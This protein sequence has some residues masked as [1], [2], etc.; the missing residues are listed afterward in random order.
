MNEFEL[1]NKYFLPLSSSDVKGDDCGIWEKVS[2]STDTSIEG[3]H[4]F[5]SMP[6]CDIA[7][8]T[9]RIAASDLYACG[10]RGVGYTLALSF[11]KTYEEKWIA[12][13]A[14]GLKKTQKALSLKLFGGDTTC[15]PGKTSIT[16]TVFGVISKQPLLR[17][18]A[19]AG[20][21]VFVSGVLGEAAAYCYLIK[22][23]ASP[24]AALYER[25]ARPPSLQ[26]L[27]EAL[28]GLASAAI[29][30]SDGLLA[31]AE[32]IAKSSKVNIT[33]QESSLPIAPTLQTLLTPKIRRTC[34]FCGG[35]DYELLFCVPPHL[36]LLIP[37]LSQQLNIPLTAIGTVTEGN[38]VIAK[39]R[40]NRT[41]SFPRQGWVHTTKPCAQR[42]A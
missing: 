28:Q 35:D 41:L 18:S 24:P 12:D 7:A 42:L 21:T 17:S 26:P 19:K 4:F 31:D 5:P 14:T 39:D 29:D 1:I 37:K 25:Y 40:N 27:G 8:R 15:T 11:P 13:F 16:I 9:L 2:I 38:G 36:L 3:V 10:S 34:A 20:D 6:A 32:Q 33:L 30:L 22:T 23:K